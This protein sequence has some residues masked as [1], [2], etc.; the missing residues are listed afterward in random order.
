MLKI[1][2]MVFVL[3]SSVSYAEESPNL[4]NQNTTSTTIN[5]VVD[6]KLKDV[7]PQDIKQS[8]TSVKVVYLVLNSDISFSKKSFIYIIPFLLIPLYLFLV[9]LFFSRVDTQIVENKIGLV[10]YHKK[11]KIRHIDGDTQ[12]VMGIGL[13]FLFLIWCAVLMFT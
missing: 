10:S 3:L 11:I 8:P 12:T 6:E 7:F 4:V 1:L 9:Y 5:K 2:L 13:I